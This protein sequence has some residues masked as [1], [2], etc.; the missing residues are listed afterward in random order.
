MR[1]LNRK[2]NS[3]AASIQETTYCSANYDKEI[4]ILAGISDALLDF[5]SQLAAILSA[6]RQAGDT[7]A[8]KPAFMRFYLSDISNQSDEVQDAMAGCGF[9][10]SLIQQAPANGTKIAVW[11]IFLSEA[12][13]KEHGG[14]LFEVKSKNERFYWAVSM[15]SPEGSS[16]EQTERIMCD[17]ASRL[18]DLNMTLARDCQRTWFYV[19][20][21]DNNYRGMVVARNKVFAQQG[22]TTET[23][24]IA[25][26]GIGG[27]S[28]NPH[29]LV[30]MEAIALPGLASSKVRYLYASDRMNRTS[31][32]GVSFERGT[33]IEMDGSCKV[34]ISGT[35]SIDSKGKVVFDRD[36][37]GQ[38]RRMIGN[39]EA[40]LREAG[41]T[42]AD[43]QQAIVY[44]RDTADYQKVRDF[45]SSNY[46]DFPH[47]IVLA[48]V[49]RPGWLIETEYMAVRPAL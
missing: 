8:V 28:A 5:K 14:G 2:Y 3:G 13:I 25:S 9:P 27:R 31:E 34:F 38:A 16:E 12:G 44:L 19:N 30:T 33:L 35:A 41:C 7:E 17:Y 47:L 43:V 6:F 49:C 22:L 15:T 42:L 36:V 20:D 26:T 32:Y 23:H 48:H 10:V 29:A 18:G 4:H 39:I 21:S 45:F 1:I 24:F 37:I 40:L 46:P 11:A